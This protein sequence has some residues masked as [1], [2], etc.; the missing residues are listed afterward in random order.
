MTVRDSI[1]R[2]GA[3]T[4]GAEDDPTSKAAHDRVLNP[5]QCGITEATT[6]CAKGGHKPNTSRCMPG[7]GLRRLMR[8][9]V[10]PYMP[11]F[12]PYRGKPAVRNDREGRGN[13]GIIRSPVRAS[14]LPDCGGRSAM[15]VPTAICLP[16]AITHSR[17]S[18]RP[19]GSCV[20]SADVSIGGAQL[21]E[22]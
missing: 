5:T 18:N 15:S 21:Y 12:Q 3:R 17:F 20:T 7:A 9:K 19:F 14:T 22:R 8:G 6:T 13:V 2:T 4:P 1:T 11:A 16:A 10:L